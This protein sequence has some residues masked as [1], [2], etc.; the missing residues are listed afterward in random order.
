M[1]EAHTNGGYDK[2]GVLWHQHSNKLLKQIMEFFPDDVPVYDLGCGHNFYV[3]VLQYFGYDAWGIDSTDLGSR[4]FT[5]Q[6][7]TKPLKFYGYGVTREKVSGNVISLEVGEHI[8]E[9]LAS[10]YLDNVASFGG[11][12]IMSWAVPGQE[13][14]GHINC[15]PNDWVI[16]EMQKRNYRMDDGRTETLRNSV[17]ECHCNWFVKTLFYFTPNGN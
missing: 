3:T 6:D 14:I 5:Q 11:D 4:Y 13:G 17:L 8:P 9:E 12:I 1:E 16:A 2:D 15:R 10:V 7:L